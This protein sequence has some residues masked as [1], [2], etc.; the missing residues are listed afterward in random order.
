MT[1]YDRG[2][3]GPAERYE[4]QRPAIYARDVRDGEDPYTGE[5]LRLSAASVDHVVP[6]HYAWEHGLPESRRDE[7]AADPLCLTVTTLHA[8]ESKG[9]KRPHDW[10]PGINT[11]W[12][13]T[14]WLQICNRYGLPIDVADRKT[15]DAAITP[16]G[17]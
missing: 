13:A 3:F 12:Y 14:R 4:R 15:L 7:F 9:D 11:A 5:P 10:M 1:D 2:L 16:S 6:I 17:P 8:N